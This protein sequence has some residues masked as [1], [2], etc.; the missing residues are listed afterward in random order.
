MGG[1]FFGIDGRGAP[2]AGYV[3]EAPGCGPLVRSGR[4][5]TWLC[6]SKTTL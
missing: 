2:E 6:A 3:R 4:R 1:A 5:Q